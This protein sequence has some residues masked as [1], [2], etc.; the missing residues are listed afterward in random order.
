MI[1]P[2]DINELHEMAS[3]P[4]EAV[5]KTLR[6]IESDILVLGAGGKMGFHLTRMIQR[7]LVKVKSDFSVIAVSRFKS[8]PTIELFEQ[9]G[10]TTIA[11]DLTDDLALAE[12]PNAQN[13][14]FLAGMKFGTSERLDLLHQMN[15]EL[16]RRVAA[17]FSSA[18]I[19]ALSTGCV[20][21]FVESESGGSVES[22]LLDPPGDYAKSCVGRE[23]AFVESV[24]RSSL[25]RLNY[26]VDLRYGVLVD[27]ANKVI[28]G[29]SVDLSTGYFNVIWQG[30]ANTYII[31]AL[32]RASSPPFVV[33]VT[34][35]RTLRVRD[36]AL[37]F[38]KLF[39]KQV[40]FVG[41]EKETAWLNNARLCH[42]LWG[43]PRI[44]EDELIEWVAEWLLKGGPTL[45]K[46][47]HFEVRDGNY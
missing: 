22:D 13:I 10:I 16:P 1:C 9:H 38:G 27:I 12:L 15:V 33:N 7:A 11:A 6:D 23:Q 37:R 20:Y 44:P 46:L 42:E 4:S 41:S 25:I 34:G 30:D 47:T 17:R 19:V 8:Q 3:R 2:G 14:F 36:V 21:P 28:S 29:R 45:D 43:P 31:C 39:G 26:S 32:E 40:D 35:P 5:M 18:R 24:A